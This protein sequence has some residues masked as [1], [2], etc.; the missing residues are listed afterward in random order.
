M[1]DRAQDFVGTWVPEH[2]RSNAEQ[3]ESWAPLVSTLVDDAQARGISKA[4]LENSLG[5][6]EMFLSA[7]VESAS[8]NS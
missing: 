3:P 5:D 4:D 2:I 6:L 1:S 8:V 7:C